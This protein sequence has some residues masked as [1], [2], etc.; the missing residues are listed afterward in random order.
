MD[1][2]RMSFKTFPCVFARIIPMPNILPL[3]YTL[4][5]YDH[6]SASCMSTARLIRNGQ[7]NRRRVAARIQPWDV[8]VR[9][10]NNIVAIAHR[11]E[12]VFARTV[13]PSNFL[14]HFKVYQ[15]SIINVEINTLI[16]IYYIKSWK[17]NILVHE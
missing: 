10:F 5:H 1:S 3:C 4:L 12:F 8:T 16:L 11:I 7:G 2:P 13:E 9:S 14:F 15:E 6:Y 17:R